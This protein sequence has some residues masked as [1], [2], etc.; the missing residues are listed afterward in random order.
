MAS[1]PVNAKSHFLIWRPESGDQRGDEMEKRHT[2]KQGEHLPKIAESYGFRD[3]R[4]IW[5]H[6]NNALLK[7]KRQNPMVLFPGDE[8]FIPDK[9]GKKVSC[10]TGQRHRFKVSRQALML[11]IV[12]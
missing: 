3:Y 2:V 9:D 8:L 10:A 1:T 7:Q 11:Q 6:P 12:I 4:T 5:D